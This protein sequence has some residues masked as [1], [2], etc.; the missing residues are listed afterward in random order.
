MF[1]EVLGR[2]W[3]A[4]ETSAALPRFAMCSEVISWWGIRTFV[5]SV[6]PTKCR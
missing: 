3:R 6:G 2:L 4:W 5:L 1:S